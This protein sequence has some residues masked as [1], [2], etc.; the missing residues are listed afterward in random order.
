MKGKLFRQAIPIKKFL[1]KDRGIKVDFLLS[2]I[3]S[4]Q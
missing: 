3:M 1:K 2:L 4:E